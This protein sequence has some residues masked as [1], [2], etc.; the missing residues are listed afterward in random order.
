MNTS[1]DF[2]APF[3]RDIQPTVLGQI[4]PESTTTTHVKV[5]ET[6]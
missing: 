3:F 6:S 1:K 5:V 2:A 4:N